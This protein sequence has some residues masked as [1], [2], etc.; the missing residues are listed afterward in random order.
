MERLAALLLWLKV[1]KLPE[2][3]QSAEPFTH[4]CTTKGNKTSRGT[5]V[6]NCLGGEAAGVP[7]CH[8]TFISGESFLQKE[9]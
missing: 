4:P 8:M 2:S 3:V 1:Q 6:G 9:C 5:L 7:M